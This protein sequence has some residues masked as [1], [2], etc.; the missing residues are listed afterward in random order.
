MSNSS[1]RYSMLMHLFPLLQRPYARDPCLVSVFAACTTIRF[2]AKNGLFN[3]STLGN[4][5]I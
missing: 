1:R 2:P 4:V 5:P 3:D